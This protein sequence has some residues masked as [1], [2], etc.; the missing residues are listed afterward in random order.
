MKTALFYSVLDRKKAIAR[1]ETL[2]LLVR[3]GWNKNMDK[4]DVAISHFR[5]LFPRQAQTTELRVLNSRTSKKGI[6]QA[7]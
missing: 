1:A 2:L 5:F 6:K 4:M 3:G 7:G